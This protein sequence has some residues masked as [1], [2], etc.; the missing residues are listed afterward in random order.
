VFDWSWA[1]AYEQNGLDYYPKLLCA[2]PYSPVTGPRLLAGRGGDA[3]ALRAALIAAIRA[4]AQRLKLSSAHLNFAI[5]SDA[6][7]FGDSDWLP[8][9]DWQFHWRNDAGWRNFEDFLGALSHKKRKNIRHERT[10]VA[11][12][13]VVCE[14]RHGDEL[15]DDEW[16]A[17]HDF[18]LAT[19]VEKATTPHCRSISFA[20][21]VARCRATSSPC[22]AGATDASSPV[23]SCCAVPRRCTAATGARANMSKRCISKPATTKASTTACVKA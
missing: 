20:T 7:A 18:Y 8:R 12:A 11:Q 5:E 14:I 2:V 17:L 4:E 3:D 15:R 9:S 6:V 1:H 16:R 10:R 19:F 13:G 21:S 22:C 23:R